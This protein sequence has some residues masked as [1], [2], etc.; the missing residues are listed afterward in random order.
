[1]LNALDYLHTHGHYIHRDMKPE[2]ILLTSDDHCKISFYLRRPLRNGEAFYISVS[3]SLHYQIRSDWRFLLRYVPYIII[4]NG[5]NASPCTT[6]LVCLSKVFQWTLFLVASVV[7]RKRLQ[8]YGFF[9]NLQ[10]IASTFFQKNC[11][12]L[13][14]FLYY[15]YVTEHIF[16]SITYSSLN[17]HSYYIR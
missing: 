3:G 12:L 4:Y 8:R 5:G 13:R 7:S 11:R 2:N 6:F 16:F 17:K 15:N 10:A 14:K 9:P 1:M